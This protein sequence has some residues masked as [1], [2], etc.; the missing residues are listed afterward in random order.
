MRFWE[1]QE[2]L[3]ESPQYVDPTTFRLDDLEFN[4]KF[5]NNLLPK[6]KEI[7]EDTPDY[8]VLKTGDGISGWIF[9]YNIERKTADYVIQYRTKAWGKWLPITVTQCVLWRNPTSLFA[10]GITN[11]IFFNYLLKTYPAIMSDKLQTANGH[12]FWTVRM[13]EAQAAGFKVGVADVKHRKMNWFEGSG[14]NNYAEWMSNQDTF[15]EADKYQDIR[16]VILGQP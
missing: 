12:D 15:G 9:L 8:Q 2:G 6:V 3:N 1:I 13:T 7:I 14:A 11:K 4:R 5:V 16:Y 10:R